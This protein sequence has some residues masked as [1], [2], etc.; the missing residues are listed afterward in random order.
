MNEEL[1]F[2]VDTAKE[3]M[4]LAIAHLEKEFNDWVSN[5]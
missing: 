1:D 2:I 3:D 4:E 5:K